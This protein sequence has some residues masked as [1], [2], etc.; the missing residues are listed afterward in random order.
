MSSRYNLRRPRAASPPTADTPGE[1]QTT[2]T[3]N[4]NVSTGSSPLSSPVPPESPHLGVSERRADRTYSQV[5]AS[6]PPS[7]SG[8]AGGENLGSVMNNIFL[9]SSTPS[10]VPPVEEPRRRVTV[11]EVTDEDEGGP[12]IQ[13][14]RRRRARST[15]S[16]PAPRVPINR[17]HSRL[18]GVQQAAV[19]RAEESLTQA[20]RERIA[21]R[22]ELSRDARRRADSTSADSRGE[23]PSDPM[24]K[25]KAIDARNW[26]AVDIP[27]SELDPE[28][29]R[30]EL[31]LYST[32]RSLRSNILDGYDSE[33]QRQMLEYWQKR[34]ETDAAARPSPSPVHG[35]EARVAAAAP[36]EPPAWALRIEELQR[37]LESLRAATA[38]HPTSESAKKK[39]R[40]KRRKS[41]SSGRVPTRETDAL[42][43]PLTSKPSARGN[44]KQRQSS[45]RPVAQL[46]PG[47]YLDRAF[48]DLIGGGDPGDSS[49]SSSSETSSSSN[50][51]R[52][53]GAARRARST[54]ESSGSSDSSS[55][56]GSIVAKHSK[57]HKKLRLK[58][59]KPEPY[60]GRA[61][62]QV[63]HKFMR[64]TVEYL[65]A[66][67]VEPAM[68]A[69][70]V[71]NFLKGNAY[72]FWVTTVESRN[73]RSWTL[74]KLFVELFNYCFPVDYRLQM[75]EKLQHSEQG[76]R[77][78]RDY[79]HELENLF[80]MVGFVSDREKVD[81]LWHGL[82]TS[83]QTEL[84][85]RELNPTRSSWEEV[86]EAAELIEIAEHVGQRLR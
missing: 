66:F 6:R 43:L 33:E 27:D 25:G 9:H 72:N 44:G 24:R 5:A 77:S 42:E 55:S 21:R 82:K 32:E 23:G 73:P 56:D 3:G 71:S 45:L 30:R 4:A 19:R 31:E 85:K 78:V 81:K 63:F 35:D 28:A 37:E 7:P 41:R 57:S 64:Q 38:Q 47:S 59:E 16:M 60:D 1:P 74:R 61:D 67:D 53:G 51:G 13:V 54:S 68:L 83:I 20:E 2:G 79:I 40:S 58:P 15:G 52:H 46:E 62:A 84:W 14:Q 22:M 26:G 69:S 49:S 75:R 34:K 17:Q 10:S 86:R 36:S 29:Q 65:S 11:E 76:N 8:D 50:A 39:E 12:W 48:Q 70:H 18:S 80:L